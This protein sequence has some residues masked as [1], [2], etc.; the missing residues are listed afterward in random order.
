MP[1][2]TTRDGA[3]LHYLDV[4][5]R[6]GPACVLLHG[7]GMQGAMW[8]PVIAPLL[9]KQRFVL[10]DLR[11]F[12]GSHALSLS[13][14]QL[15]EQHADDLADL[16]DGLGLEEVR[17]AGLS[18]GACTAMDYHARYG[19]GRVHSYLHIDQAP[20][21][22]NGADWQH[23][24]LGAGQADKLADWGDLLQRL[25]IYRD[26]PFER[27][28]NHLRLRFWGV[29]ADFLGHAFSHR[30]WQAA[31]R[32]TRHD[33]LAK[34]LVPTANWSVYVDSLRSYLE[35]GF[36]WRESLKTLDKPMTVMIGGR[37]AMYPAE[38]Q[39]LLGE[40]VPH[41]QLIEFPTSGHVIPFESPRR[42]VA[43]F[44]RFLRAA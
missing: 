33:Q 20:R 13:R 42:F 8:L 14:P 3:R 24:V 39:R 19:F 1:H 27:V 2:L 44:G 25:K 34:R 21:I 23:G 36:D 9:L 11:G 12:G 37:S 15:I 40:L 35:D 28:P 4:G 10:P 32:L 29:L 26:T 22:L 38:G 31:A 30:G 17:L 43:E 16:I 5:A 18:M 41:A 7:F 6:R